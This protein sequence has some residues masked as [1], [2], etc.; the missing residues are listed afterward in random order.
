TWRLA[1]VH[2]PSK[3]TPDIDE[4]NELLVQMQLKALQSTTSFAQ[5]MSRDTVQMDYNQALLH[6]Y[7]FDLVI[8]E[9]FIGDGPARHSKQRLNTQLDIMERIT[10]DVK[11]EWANLFYESIE[12]KIVYQRGQGKENEHH[13]KQIEAQAQAIISK[14]DLGHASDP[15]ENMP[16][17]KS[18]SPLQSHSSMV[19]LQDT[20]SEEMASP[21]SK[22]HTQRTSIASATKEKDRFAK[23][24]TVGELREY[25][26]ESFEHW[27]KSKEVL[28]IVREFLDAATTLIFKTHGTYLRELMM[29]ADKDDV[30]EEDT[31]DALQSKADF[32]RMVYLF[33][34]LFCFFFFF[35]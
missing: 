25:F 24:R 11:V 35:E 23:F 10:S 34:D 30:E 9:Q 1:S 13:S 16:P 26:F 27:C 18:L 19:D 17:L 15:E 21:K 31:S 32:P 2:A 20:T 7:T 22:E 6:T 5:A 29:G 8:D 3:E 14:D 33:V 12:D 4:W 28:W